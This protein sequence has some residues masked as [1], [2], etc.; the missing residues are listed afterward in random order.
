MTDEAKAR[1]VGRPRD[2]RVDE[3]ILSA[4]LELVMEGGFG[5][6]TIDAVAQ[7][8]GVGKATIYRRWSGK[9]EL[10]LD[11]MQ[12]SSGVEP[13]PSTGDLRTDLISAYEPFTDPS[14]QHATIGLMPA[15]AAEAAV[16]PD[17]AGHLRAFVASRRTPVRALVQAALADGRL[18]ADTD[19]ELTL[20]LMTG[21]LL[22]RMFFSGGTVDMSVV[23]HTIDL[24]LKACAPDA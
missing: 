16:D 22:Y 8:A 3:A 12:S 20:D 14:R 19:V 9:E 6:L 2:P 23:E 13:F 24:V 18:A 17:L 7:R 21:G 5:R 11:A 10:V 15:L 1:P 4:V